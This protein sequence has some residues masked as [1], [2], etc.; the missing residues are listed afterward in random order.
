MPAV[1]LRS[2]RST[3][4]KPVSAAVPGGPLPVGAI[5]TSDMQLTPEQR[6]VMNRLGAKLPPSNVVPQTLKKQAVQ[7]AEEIESQLKLP[8]KALEMPKSVDV[9]EL[10]AQKQAELLRSLQDY[11]AAIATETANFRK[12]ESGPVEPTPPNRVDLTAAAEEPTQP[13][14]KVPSAIGVPVKTFCHHCG[15]DQTQKDPEDPS[16]EDKLNFIQAIL[17]QQ[18]FLKAY[19]LL[20][21]RVTVVFRTLTNSETDTCFTQTAYDAQNGAIEGPLQYMRTL[22]D[23]RLCLG[24]SVIDLGDHKPKQLPEMAEYVCD[25]PPANT[26]VLKQVVPYIYDKVL[27]QES[28]R[29]T[30]AAAYFRFQRLVEKMEAHIDDANFWLAIDG[31]P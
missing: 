24:L 20:G 27:V 22:A 9:C 25:T 31:Q 17:G 11:N 5:M 3:P 6:A 30:C 28:I 12:L 16:D 10:S 26:T 14:D 29:R 1:D 2:K 13:D 23:Y 7:Q 15:W 21:G 8:E 4:V 18:R 19:S